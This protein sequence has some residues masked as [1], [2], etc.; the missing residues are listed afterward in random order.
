M[1]EETDVKNDDSCIAGYIE[2]VPLASG[3]DNSGA[4]ECDE[5]HHCDEIKQELLQ[6]IKHEAVELQEF[7]DVDKDTC[8]A[9]DVRPCLCIF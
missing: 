6:D 8:A 4:G 5:L 2:I 3:R 1:S 7:V 9:G